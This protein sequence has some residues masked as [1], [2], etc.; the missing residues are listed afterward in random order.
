MPLQLNADEM[1]IVLSL[2]LT[3]QRKYFSPPQFREGEPAR[4][5]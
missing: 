1:A 3:I 4:R 2:A 5:A